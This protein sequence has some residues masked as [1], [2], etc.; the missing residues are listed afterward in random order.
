M[1]TSTGLIIIGVLAL[2]AFSY[3]YFTDRRKTIEVIENG[4][5]TINVKEDE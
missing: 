1:K 5:F 3:W 4:S 2:G